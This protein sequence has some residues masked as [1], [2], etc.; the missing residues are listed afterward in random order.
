MSGF[1]FG[2]SLFKCA[3]QPFEA[4]RIRLEY[5]RGLDSNR[6]QTITSN[7]QRNFFNGSLWSSKQFSAT[8]PQAKE[9]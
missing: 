4:H 5:G 6:E 2:C 9:R 8:Q 1:G 7:V 3:L